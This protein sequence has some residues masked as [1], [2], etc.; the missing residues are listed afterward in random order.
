MGVGKEGR[1]GPW[2]LS[3]TVTPQLQG[4][5][6][7]VSFSLS[8]PVSVSLLVSLL[9]LSSLAVSTSCLLALLRPHHPGGS[10]AM[11]P[12]Y[13]SDQAPLPPLVPATLLPAFAPHSSSP[14]PPAHPCFS[15]TPRPTSGSRSASELSLPFFSRSSQSFGTTQLR[16]SSVTT[17]LPGTQ[18]SLLL[19]V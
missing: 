7:T 2:A 9:S 5:P 19:G 11:C 6:L 1:A 13:V 3:V 4:L 8:S 15:G 18:P 16:Q 10:E 17:E 14:P 12:W